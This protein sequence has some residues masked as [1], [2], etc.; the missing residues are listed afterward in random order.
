M[1]SP[2]PGMDPYLEGYLWPDVHQALAGRIRQQ[3]TPQIRPKYVARLEIYM[4]QDAQPE[5]EVGIMY[6]DVEVLARREL[7]ERPSPPSPPSTAVAPSP[8]APLTLSLPAPVPVRVPTVEIRDTAQNQL[9][10]AIEI[11]SPVNKRG[12]GLEAYREKQ[13]RLREAGVHVLEIDLLRRGE[14][15]LR[16]SR[17]PQSDYLLTLTRA[18]AGR[19]EVWPLALADPLPV[20][21]VPLRDPDPDVALDLGKALRRIYDE[22]AYDLSLDYEQPPPPPPLNEEETAWIREQIAS[23]EE[24]E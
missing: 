18:G 12:P 13:R 19:V 1:P 22:A 10:T 5:M 6:P 20:L 2:F 16:H 9:V 15:P 14:R 8:D 17:L 23:V 4:V 11:L 7:R 21:P 3:L 24:G